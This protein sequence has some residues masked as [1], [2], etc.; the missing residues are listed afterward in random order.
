MAAHPP[1]HPTFPTIGAILP[2]VSGF[3]MGE[4]TATLRELAIQHQFNLVIVRAGHNGDLELGA[5]FSQIDALL[6]VHHCASAKLVAESINRGIPVMSIG[7]SYAPLKV[8]QIY[9]DQSHGIALLYQWLQ[10]KGHTE[11]GFCG[12][13]SINDIRIRFK[14][15]QMQ[16]KN[17]GREFDSAQLFNVSDASLSGGREA[18]KQYSNKNS[19]CT[20]I[21][22]A[23]DHNAIGMI[24]KLNQNGINVPEDLAIVGVDNI[25]LGANHAPTLTSIDQQ[26]EALTTQAISRL[27]E[28][29]GGDQF[30]PQPKHIPQQLV[31]RSSCGAD[32]SEQQLLE[33]TG[34]VRQQL[35]HKSERSPAEMFEALY[36][37]AKS[38]FDSL[39]NLPGLYNASMAWACITNVK[40]QRCNIS[41][42]AEKGASYPEKLTKP[43]RC[44]IGRFPPHQIA[45]LSMP[46]HSLTTLI[47]I[48]NGETDQWQVIG[49][50]DN[51]ACSATTSEYAMHNYYLD[52]LSLF[53]ERDAL[54]ET[55][56]KRQQDSQSL[57]N[58]LQVV[59]KTSND[60]IWDWDLTTNILNWN[61]RL[62]DM[63]KLTEVE[64]KNSIACDQLFDRVHPDDLEQLE[65]GIS[66][67]IL[68]NTPFKGSFRARRQDGKYL[69]LQINGSA[70][71]D[72]SGRP[73]RLIGSMT[74]VTAQKES[75]D[76][77]HHMA[78]Y[79]AL[80]GVPNRRMVMEKLQTTIAD[81]PEQKLA[82]MLMDLN[83]FKLINDTYGHHV[84]DAL[85]CH[86]ANRL[87]KVMRQQDICARLGG[88]EFLFMCP[89]DHPAQ[90]REIASQILKVVEAPLHLPNVEVHGQGCL[91]IALYPQDAT[92]SEELV[93]N[94]DIAMYRAK[95]YRS[96]QLTFYKNDMERESHQTISIEQALIKALDK[97][98]LEVWYQ[99]QYCTQ[100]MQP[101]GAEALVRWH[102]KAKGILSP[103]EFI[104]VAEETGLIGRLGNFVLNKVCVDLSH[105]AMKSL[106]QVSINVSPRQLC[107]PRYAQEALQTIL[108]YDLPP[109]RFCFEV[110]ESCI[111]EDEKYALENL[112][113]L[114]N[115]GVKI[116]LDDFGTGY[117]SL[118][119]LKQL[120]LNEVKID[121]SFISELNH[122]DASRTMVHSIITMCHAF[123]H[124]V[125]AEGVETCQ[126][127]KI[128]AEMSCDYSQGYLFAKPMPLS[129]LPTHFLQ[130]ADLAKVASTASLATT[131]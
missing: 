120:P 116:A 3:Y 60:G 83:R 32:I 70:I 57:L 42:I 113:Y 117:S 6:V 65:Q 47:P 1:H 30:D 9:S 45:Q 16:L 76:K 55:S 67:H 69:W 127:A 107:Q 102:S 36:S 114:A 75:A 22:C 97:G 41:H 11:I 105:P 51:L 58:Q 17:A 131:E 96:R 94:A 37:Q 8:E 106:C 90:A 15:F 10:S 64:G 29:L 27:L 71:R 124:K 68:E 122:D 128:L 86:V 19:R 21:I 89:I 88:D 103:A 35:V 23:T 34:S 85:L 31:V 74:D 119:L 84:G 130:Q 12:D 20:A 126:Q 61:S 115:A 80:T 98:E 44:D 104:P 99:P 73:V 56:Q 28:R 101:I 123:G 82:I 112:Q 4:I 91:G 78:Y 54:L 24:E 13:L 40:G 63:L 118:S 72:D 129:D 26:L 14:S 49:H 50:I 100:N 38:G 39:L 18:A 108:M 111:I 79:D 2:M 53:M 95:Q 33:Q 125:T 46:R 25:F 77:I 66:D 109:E 92:H 62:L 93:K 43:V 87:K 59:S 81:H 5:S 7:A 110:T 52:M 121:R 48:C